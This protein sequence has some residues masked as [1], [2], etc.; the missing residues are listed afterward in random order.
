MTVHPGSRRTTD[1]RDRL[2]LAPCHIVLRWA[3]CVAPIGESDGPRPDMDPGHPSGTPPTLQSH[4]GLPV[5]SRRTSGEAPSNSPSRNRLRKPVA[6]KMCR[7][8]QTD[9]ELFFAG[10]PPTLE[11]S[12][13]EFQV[14]GGFPQHELKCNQSSGQRSKYAM[15]HSG[16]G[17]ATT[18]EE[19]CGQIRSQ[20]CQQC[21]FSIAR[22]LEQWMHTLTAVESSTRVYARPVHCKPA[23]D[24]VTLV[25]EMDYRVEF[26]E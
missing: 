20:N 18:T 5:S 14:A 16:L 7:A 12:R 25:G 1:A 4:T 2:Y 9:S 13:R 17:G 15:Q 11:A 6:C 23:S 10:K 8:T 24:F 19:Q 3:E 22:T 21:E 26:A